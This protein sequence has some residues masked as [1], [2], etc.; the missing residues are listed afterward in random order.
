MITVHAPAKLNLSLRIRQPDA[1]G[2]H[3]L[4][5]LVQTVGWH[6]IVTM[7]EADDDQLHVVGADLPDDGENLV[8]RAVHAIRE[9]GR[10]TRPV[11]MTLTK[12]IPAAAGLGGGSSDA[13]AALLAYAELARFER[14]LLADL[15]VGIGADVPYLLEGG[16]RVIEG[17]GE[18]LSE[19]QAQADD[20]QVVVA[21]PD[22][23]LSTP[24][25]YREWDR[26][27]GPD[28]PSLPIHAVPPSLRSDDR[29]VNDLYPAAVS[30][31]PMVAD[32]RAE[33]AERWDRPVAMSGSGPALFAF[34]TDADEAAEGLS[35]VPSE[36]R[37][38]FAAP[39]IDHGARIV[40]RAD[41]S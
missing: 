30:L 29:L 23:E 31:E 16:L 27:D 41:G 2:L 39:P 1:T 37:G 3:P 35:A 8:W 17:Y 33:L 24:A 15:A 12:R 19:K 28:G 18:R 22:F 4:I 40:D 14:D 21:V 13:A 10:H 26:L 36:A 9:A 6:D 34:F 7:S 11:S 5:S 32:W 20:Y 38:A 25:V